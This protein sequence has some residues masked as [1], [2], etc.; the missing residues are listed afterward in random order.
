MCA[1]MTKRHVGTSRLP[2]YAAAVLLLLTGCST[3]PGDLPADALGSRDSEGTACT[4]V[5]AQGV[6]S[7]ATQFLTNT[8][9]STITVESVEVDG[10]VT[11]DDW[12]LA[13]IDWYVPIAAP[14]TFEDH[15]EDFDATSLEPGARAILAMT[16]KTEP[17]AATDPKQVTARIQ[18]DE[19]ATGTAVMGFEVATGPANS[20]CQ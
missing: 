3:G 16:L 19:G 13:P 18:S 17:S 14:G 11:V 1:V 8:T 7:F 9:D 10:S 20:G 6:A 4:P 5:D 12:F 2:L 15:P